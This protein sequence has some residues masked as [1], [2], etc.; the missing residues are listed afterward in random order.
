MAVRG[1]FPC[2]TSTATGSDHLVHLRGDYTGENPAHIQTMN[3]TFTFTLLLVAMAALE[4]KSGEILKG[5][6]CIIYKLRQYVLDII[7]FIL[8]VYGHV[9]DG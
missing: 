6:A 8:M 1:V 2:F 7:C 4:T 9:K 3:L 5:T